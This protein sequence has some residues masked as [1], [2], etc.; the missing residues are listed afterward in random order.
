M[1]TNEEAIWLKV[2]GL[3]CS[4]IN[5]EVR[6]F[7]FSTGYPE[8]WDYLEVQ[9]CDSCGGIYSNHDE[10]CRNPDVDEDD[11]PKVCEYGGS[12]DIPE[13]PMM[14][15]LWGFGDISPQF[16]ESTARKIID[17]N[18]CLVFIEDEDKTYLALTGGGMDLSWDIA[19]AYIKLGY[20]PPAK[21]SLPN[22]AGTDP[23]SDNN[24]LIIAAMKESYRVQAMWAEQRNAD[25]DRKI[26]AMRD[27][28]EERKE[29]K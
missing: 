12:N 7:D 2:E 14:N 4:S 21:I 11:E 23:N 20:L 5:I 29:E 6:E 25:L 16:D 3:Y 24:K 26:K 8:Q 22:L 27:Y 13:G 1:V 19:E 10:N 15:F 9:K 17:V 18:M 28:N